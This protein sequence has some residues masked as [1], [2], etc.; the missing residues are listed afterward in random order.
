MFFDLVEEVIPSSDQTAL[1]LIVDQVQLI[2]VPHFTDLKNTKQIISFLKNKQ[3]NN[4]N[5]LLLMMS[6]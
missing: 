4:N 5:D 3:T 6:P 2:R 1:V